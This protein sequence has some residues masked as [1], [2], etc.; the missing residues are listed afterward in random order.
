MKFYL[1]FAV[2]VGLA[3]C[4]P[5]PPQ[6]A[7]NTQAYFDLNTWL[8]DQLDQLKQS[9]VGMNKTILI[10][11]EKD[12]TSVKPQLIDWENTLDIFRELDINKPNYLNSFEVEEQAEQGG[13]VIRYFA[14]DPLLKVQQ[15]EVRFEGDQLVSLSG[16]IQEENLF[17]VSKRHFQINASATGRLESLSLSGFQKLVAKD[18]M[19]YEIHLQLAGR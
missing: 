12:Q 4:R 7:I 13:K 5:D 6:Q 9:E 18:T 14:K 10:N 1:V 17:F 8:D 15:M 16:E 3:A 11:G 2:L 19:Q